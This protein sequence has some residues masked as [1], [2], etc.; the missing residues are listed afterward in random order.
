MRG[1]SSAVK[2]GILVILVGAGGYAIYQTVG[3]RPAGSSSFE[4]WADFDDAS[5]LPKGSAVL[6]AGLPV[7]QIED[8]S[9]RGRK[10]RITMKLRDDVEMWSNA[11]VFKKSSSLLG[12]FF[13]EI[14]PGTEVIA[15]ADGSQQT[16]VRMKS[17]EQ[18]KNVVEA[19]S[20]DQILRRF[21]ETMPKVDSLVISVRELSEN[22]RAIVNG[23]VKSI[24]DNIDE[25]VR[26][27]AKTVSSILQ[28]TD[29]TVARIESV[30]ADIKRSTAAGGKVDSI[31][32]LR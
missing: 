7:G 6:V 11:V 25:L 19:A 31:S 23:P 22:M 16:N 30:V 24:A 27:E 32:T 20:I 8:L 2:V 4:V 26:D 3:Q 29:R 18:V 17:G 5:G 14:D 12:A 21:E 10:A 28:R 1:V 15:L 13:L 9:I